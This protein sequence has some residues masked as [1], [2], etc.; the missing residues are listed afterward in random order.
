MRQDISYLLRTVTYTRLSGVEVLSSRSAKASDNV[1]ASRVACSDNGTRVLAGA[2]WLKSPDRCEY[3][4]I[5]YWPS[6]HGQPLNSYNLWQS[7]GIEPKQGDWSVIDDHILNVI[8][9]GDRGKANYILDWIAH[10]VQR[11][12]E[13]PGVALVLTGAKGTGKSLLTDN[14]FSCYRQPKH[15]DYVV[16][17]GAVRKVQ[18]ASNRQV[19]D[20]C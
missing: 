1:F 4:E 16:R 15:F 6:G 20:R 7:W 3:A 12:W 10:M 17:Q 11:P 2:A 5:G 13:K 8:A 9:N 14:P 18:L 19:I